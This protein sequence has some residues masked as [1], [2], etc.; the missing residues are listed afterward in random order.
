MGQNFI[1]NNQKK[2]AHYQQMQ[3]EQRLEKLSELVKHLILFGGVFA[4]VCYYLYR[5]RNTTGCDW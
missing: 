1:R 2:Q 5:F 3:Q 4:H